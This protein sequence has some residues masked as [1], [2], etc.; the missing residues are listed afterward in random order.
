MASSISIIPSYFA[1]TGL[2]PR[3]IASHL[4]F[5]LNSSTFFFPLKNGSFKLRNAPPLSPKALSAR[6]PK[7]AVV[8]KDTWEKSV[9]NSDSPVLVEFYASWCGPCRMVH[10]IIDEIAGEYAGRLSCFILNTDDDF[11]IAEDYEIK[12]V[13]VVL[14]FKNGEKR[15]SVVGTMPKDFYIAAIE[16]VLKS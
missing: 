11:P 8:T 10:R 9:L 15:E 13:P 3:P 7:A 12:A 14:L 1:S 4:P 16:R 5:N 6:A 2:P